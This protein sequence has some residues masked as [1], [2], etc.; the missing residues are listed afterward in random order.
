MSMIIDDRLGRCSS[1]WMSSGDA[2]GIQLL[3]ASVSSLRSLAPS[4][5][6]C[7]AGSHSTRW[8]RLAL[9]LGLRAAFEKVLILHLLLGKTKATELAQTNK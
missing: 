8:T 4:F 1:T 3:D 5:T 9:A 7:F 6:A 2:S